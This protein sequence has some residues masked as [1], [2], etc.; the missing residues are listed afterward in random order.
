MHLIMFLWPAIEVDGSGDS[1]CNI[2]G[3]PRAVASI[4][5]GEGHVCSEAIARADDEDGNEPESIQKLLA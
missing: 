4:M 5:K 1:D 3:M 2:D